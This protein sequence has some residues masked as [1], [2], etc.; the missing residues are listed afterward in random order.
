MKIGMI[1]A[2]FIARG[3]AIHAIRNGHEV[4]LSNSRGP[5]TLGSTAVPFDAS[6][7]T[8]ALAATTRSQFVAEGSWRT[9]Q[10]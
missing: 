6:G 10:C 9:R 2:G 1:G 7:L 4:M 5:R 8:R 3:L